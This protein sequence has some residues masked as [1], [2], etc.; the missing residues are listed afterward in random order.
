MG[1]VYRGHQ[2]GLER[3]VAIKILPPNLAAE[4]EFRDRFL[5]EAQKLAQLTHANIVQIFDFGNEAGHTYMAMQLV[6]GEN[7]QERLAAAG[8][9]GPIEVARIGL[10]VARGL[11]RAHR[12]GIIHRDI[13]PANVFLGADGEIRLGDFGLVKEIGGT[14]QPLTQTGVV[15]GTPHYMAPEQCEGLPDVDH[16]ADLFAL[17][18]V[19]YHCLTGILPA[20]G[21]TPLQII[22]NR[23]ST[24]LDPLRELAPE[25][26]GP[27]A[28][29]VEELLIRDRDKRLASA[30]ELASRL[31]RFMQQGGDT[32]DIATVMVRTTPPHKV[33][34]AR[35]VS[36]SSDADL[37]VLPTVAAPTGHLTPTPP[38]P[39]TPPRSGAPVAV[40]TQGSSTALYVVLGCL[41]L[42]VVGFF[43]L[44]FLGALANAGNQ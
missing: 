30:S 20:K 16:R 35:L 42:L 19:L 5:L 23:L 18:L 32:A 33:P 7:L 6:D 38:A 41:T 12:D 15:L 3:P 39:P 44:L 36:H 29:V 26:P 11:A 43:G 8:K 27:L 40:A 17:G 24:E 28:Y 1:A 37:P 10:G 13:K 31:D 21:K 22:H 9:L 2:V 34:T 4:A 25:V 14:D